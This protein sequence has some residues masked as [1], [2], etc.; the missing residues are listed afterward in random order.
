MSNT[1]HLDV[2][3]ACSWNPLPQLAEEAYS[4]QISVFDYQIGRHMP[5]WRH[6]KI[7]DTVIYSIDDITVCSGEIT[8]VKSKAFRPRWRPDNELYVMFIDFAQTMCCQTFDKK[9]AQFMKRQHVLA[10][11]QKRWMFVVCAI[12]QPTLHYTSNRAILEERVKE[13]IAFEDEQAKMSSPFWMGD[14]VNE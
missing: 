2:K 7:G 10:M 5:L 12:I 6:S 4:E 8:F 9:W 14:M 11:E 1:I 3:S 13:A